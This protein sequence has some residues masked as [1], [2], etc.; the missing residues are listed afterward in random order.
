MSLIAELKRR[1]VYRAAVFYAASA[2]LLVQV[3][4]QVF[5]FFHIAEWVVRWIV[6]AAVVGFPFLLAFAWFYEWTPEGLKRESDVAAA[7]S[8]THHTGKK[9]DRWIIAVLGA[10]VVLLLTDRFVLHKD[11]VSGTADNSIAVLPLINESGDANDEYFSDGLSEDLINALTQLNGL[12]VIS[13]N[14]SFQFKG[15]TGDSQSI[16]SRLGV[17][18][19]L[20]GTV[21]KLGN[22]LRISAALIHAADGSQVW[23]Q[24]FDREYKDIFD[25]QAEIAQ[26][27]AQALRIRLLGD[28]TSA[29]VSQDRPPDGNLQAYEAYLQGNFYYDRIT[30]TD[31]RKAIDYYQQ[32]VKLEPRYALALARLSLT[33]TEL[34]GQLGG[35]EQSEAYASGRATAQQALALE[36]NLARAHDAFGWLLL[37]ADWNLAGARAEFAKAEALAPDD[38]FAKN[39]LAAVH[40]D[41]GRQE[42]AV[43]IQRRAVALDPLHGHYR[44]FLGQYLLALGRLDEAEASFRKGLEI[45]PGELGANAE[46]VSIHVLRGDVA[47]ALRDAELEADPTW[48]RFARALALF[49]SGNRTAADTA[50]QELIVNDAEWSSFQIASVYA[51]RKEADKAFEWLDQ[52]LVRRDGGTVQLL[53]DPF[54]TSFRSDPRF[55]AFCRKVGL[56]V[57]GEQPAPLARAPP[58]EPG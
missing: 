43:A 39:G 54:L 11:A 15:K 20:E 3:A 40:S 44:V 35:V 31:F 24:T 51:Y 52:A 46:L 58:S 22:R 12:R 7:E 42:E 1:N 13:R 29:I 49:A 9:L 18:S 26:A 30:K 55:A 6:V 47:A 48:K 41:L 50:L 8:I 17:N 37:S 36:P 57:P 53:A 19:L 5:P 38:A 23:A 28:T 56:P 34:G 4:T 16:G 14:S 32:A 45:Q 27:V 10:A 33:W 21:R 2:W 25:V